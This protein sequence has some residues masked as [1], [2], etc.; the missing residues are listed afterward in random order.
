MPMNAQS[1]IVADSLIVGCWQL[2]DRSWKSITE[3][4]IERA[5][6]TYLALGIST[7][8]TADIYGR[9]EQILGKI[10][11]KT[12]CKIFTKAVF[13]GDIPTPH[14]IHFKVEN[15]LRNLQ[16]ERLDCLQIHW[17]NP[18]LDFSYTLETVGKLL[19]QGKIEQ[20]GVT[21]FNTSMLEKALTIV[22]I[23]THQ[24]QYSPIDR[25][26]EN[27]MQEFCLKNELKILAYGPLA[28][29]YLSN[30]FYGMS[31]MPK[32][33]GHARGFYYN[34]AIAAHGGWQPVQ[35][36]LATLKKIA[37]KYEM[38]IAQVALNWVNN[39]PGVHGVISGLTQDREIIKK[40]VAAFSKTISSEDLELISHTS[41]LLF[42]QKGDIYSYERGY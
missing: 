30:K 31:S 15:S 12:K 4:D 6:N 9:S 10:L 24:L 13:F 19:E 36:L 22:P 18:N 29:G 33:K 42:I 35:E 25:R 34:N 17:H 16:R 14:Q 7:F 26:V 39:Q 40:N 3:L 32:E 41:K 23:K 27:F 38:T 21:N 11:H 1:T 8:D 28:G 37:D 2:D 20:V 5:I